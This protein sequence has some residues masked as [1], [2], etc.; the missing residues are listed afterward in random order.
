MR[1][2]AALLPLLLASCSAGRPPAADAPR[3]SVLLVTLDT[4]RADHLAAYGRKQAATPRLDA[5]A[6][7]GVRFETAI[8]V[9]P[10]TAPSHASVLTGLLPPRHGVR[11]NGA[12]VLPSNLPVVAERFAHAGYA[13]GAFVSGFPLDRRFG[14]ARGFTVYDDRLPRG[15]D[16]RRAPYVERRADRTTDAAL[17]F[18]GES[19][20]RPFFAWVHYFDA[21]APYEPP[22]PFAERFAAAPYD[23]EIA[24]VD[25]QLGRL[26]DAVANRPCYV[27]VT[28]DHGESLGEHG[29][30]T[31]G[32]FVYDATLRVPLVVA[33]P[34]LGP[35]VSD[36]L[37][38]SYDVA[39]TL[40]DLAAIEA[41]S[42]IDGRSLRPALEGRAMSDEPAYS[43]S[44]FAQ[45]NLGWAPLFAWR[46]RDHKLVAAPRSE[47]YDVAADPGETQDRADGDAP[48]VE[49]LRRALD[50]A[51]ASVAPAPAPSADA[52]SRERLRALGY[53][54]FAQPAGS[55]SGRDPKDG[56]ALVRRLERGMAEA[57]ANPRF[58]V[59]ELDAV[60]AADPRVAVAYRT[61]AIA[62]QSSAE[63]K[64]ALADLDALAKLSPPTLE[65]AMLRAETL[66]LMGRAEAALK[67]TQAAAA[68]HPG[69]PDAELFRGRAL[70]SLGRRGEAVGAFEA[71]LA[72]S[73]GNGEALRSL[74]DLALER[75]DLGT[76]SQR[77]AEVLALDPADAGV[78]GRMGLVRAREGRVPEA[79]PLFQ[80]AL[81]IDP[82]NAEARVG[83]GGAL[84]RLGRPQEAIVHFERA[85][86]EA[87]PTSAALNG[88]GLARLETGDRT[89]GLAALRRSL[90]LDPAQPRIAALVREEQA[91]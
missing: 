14:F 64:A 9:A 71:A 47:L 91:R 22:A 77:Y 25:E 3:P 80:Q 1:H 66:R 70:L 31:H 26:L 57:R 60:L 19:G 46:T 41:L 16:R 12:F 82:S 29:E 48:R 75:G 8:A 39:P 20:A 62:H 74:A 33:G 7:R 24:F 34:G 76:A 45:L 50:A 85:V 15:D 54:A 84:A 11:D 83:L 86:R 4:V 67:V 88:L 52:D 53:V 90:Q 10:L 32:L 30:D 17:R 89:G 78:L 2:A 49:A 6:A 37:A 28:A 87:G 63:W 61:R 44:L 38:R 36:V 43:E 23:G 73:P 59:R 35:R 5:L 13:T 56:V 42:P 68:A 72:R 51:L 65:D 18:L 58:A 21:H 81:E 69:A 55:G 79:L 40:L 27:V